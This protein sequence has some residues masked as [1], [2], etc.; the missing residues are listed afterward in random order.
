[1]KKNKHSKEILSELLSITVNDEFRFHPTRKFRFDYVIEEV[2]IGIEI[3]GGVFIGGRHT[4]GVGY[5]NDCE[6]YNLAQLQGY[7][8]LRYLPSQI[9]Q[10]EAIEQIKEAIKL[11]RENKI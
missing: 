10:E 2:K 1:M 3:E 7:V 5:K 9:L 4:S 8:V 6:K 11:R